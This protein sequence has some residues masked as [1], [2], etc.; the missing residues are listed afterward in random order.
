V[1]TAPRTS[2]ATTGGIGASEQALTSIGKDIDATAAAADIRSK[3]PECAKGGPGGNHQQPLDQRVPDKWMGIAPDRVLC[4]LVRHRR[5]FQPL[6]IKRGHGKF[7]SL[8]FERA[9]AI[10][11]G[12]NDGDE[13]QNAGKE[14]QETH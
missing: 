6:L 10:V 9:R 3:Q 11:N 12:C 13:Q 2:Y 8:A 1:L 7:G 14:T 4:V 5:Q